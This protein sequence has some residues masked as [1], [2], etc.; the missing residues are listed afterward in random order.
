MGEAAQIRPRGR[1][2]QT[3]ILLALS[4]VWYLYH[5]RTS[6]SLSTLRAPRRARAG[7]RPLWRASLSTLTCVTRTHRHTAHQHPTIDHA[8]HTDTTSVG[9]SITS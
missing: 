5:V 2:A 4:A 8:A 9:L 3:G 7:R 6:L 1:S